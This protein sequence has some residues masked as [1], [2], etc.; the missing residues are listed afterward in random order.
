MRV[1]AA[2]KNGRAHRRATAVLVGLVAAVLTW[3]GDAEAA[4]EFAEGPCPPA[5]ARTFP[6]ELRVDCGTLVV[7][8]SRAQPGGREVRL[9]VAIMRSR[10]AKPAPDPI[11]FIQGGPAAGAIVPEL[12]TPYFWPFLAS[13]D[14]ILL[15]Q[16]GT[17][18]SE[19]SL[20][21]PELD[22]VAAHAYPNLPARPEYLAGVRACKERLT[23]EGIDLAA[24]TDADSAADIRD[25]RAALSVEEWNLLALSA[26]GGL[27]LTTMRLYPEGIRSVVFDSAW[28]N[29]TIWG[30]NFWLNADRYLSLLFKQCA[31]QPDCAAAYPTLPQDFDELTRRLD[32]NPLS[33]TVPTPSPA[34]AELVGEAQRLA[35][36]RPDVRVGPVQYLRGNRTAI[37]PL[38]YTEGDDAAIDLA[39][40]LQK[41][42]EVEEPGASRTVVGG[43]ALWAAYKPVA[44]DELTKAE[45]YGF[46]VI[47]V[48]LLAGFGTLVAA[49]TPLVVGFISVFVTAAIVF[50][51]SRV[52][53]MSIFVTN[54]A[55]M[56]GIGVAVD[57]SLFIVSR[58]RE[59]L[60]RGLSRDDALRTA[61]STSGNAV[62]FSG[63]TVV[64]SLAGLLLVDM[65][66]VR[67]MAIGAMIVVAVAVVTS[68]TLVP[69]LLAFVGPNIERFRLPLPWGTS[70]EGG[71]EF[72]PRWTRRVLARPVLSLTVSVA[73]LLLLAAP[74]L[75][76]QPFERALELLPSDSSTR[77]ATEQVKRTA[78]AGATGPVHVLVSSQA[79]AAEI[80]AELPEVPG[81]AAIGPTLSNAEGSHYLTE[82]YLDADPE[83]GAAEDAY[84]RL[85][86]RLHPIAAKHGASVV[87][88]GTTA[89]LLAIKTTIFGSLWKLV[90]FIVAVSFIVLLFLLRSIFLPLK[91]VVMTML[92][93]AAAF[94]V[95]VA[96][97][98][99]GWLDWTGFDSPGYIDSLTPALILAITFGLSMDYEVFLLG[100]IKERYKE[101]GSTDEAVAEGLQHSARIIT[102]AALIMIAV[103][104]AFAL[105]GSIQLRQLGVGLAVA[106]ALDA[107]LVRLVIV[108]STMKLLGDWN[109]WL[110]RRVEEL[111]PRLEA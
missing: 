78:G 9:A 15:D 42:L 79:A 21:C 59:E 104:G 85:E 106:I 109:W 18:Y 31:D 29:R 67:S 20:A 61:L 77:V 6:T 105:A 26:G 107:T 13:R 24:Y 52:Y 92:S 87:L 76:M 8:E 96:V 43:P 110:P 19:P 93:V 4:G 98:Q 90:L 37:V 41:E 60:R 16:R 81:V 99:W 1:W 54:M 95:L 86:D 44:K 51:L 91:A 63:A 28:S 103:F 48:I 101:T 30:P 50:W 64:A 14:V 49:G 46:P 36:T 57:Y 66:A 111:L 45:L 80:R 74:T 82:A 22:R 102:N 3:T 40:A 94:G 75:G 108:P 65:N 88:G 7:P 83:S 2:E 17:G 73:F 38:T 47:L 97:F 84:R 27:A 72:W 35:A 56:I 10:A 100:R 71:G 25:L 32:A 68:I 11:L 89:N 33:V 34:I 62:V 69:A 55:S 53:T 23:G 58:F 5:A 12:V 39:E 70:S